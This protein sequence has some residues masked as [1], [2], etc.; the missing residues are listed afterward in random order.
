MTLSGL[1]EAQLQNWLQAVR[2]IAALDEAA[3]LREVD[4]LAF[5]LAAAVENADREIGEELGRGLEAGKERLKQDLAAARLNLQY[6]SRIGAF[7]AIHLRQS[8]YYTE[9]EAERQEA[10]TLAEQLEVAFAGAQI[11]RALIEPIA[12][13]ASLPKH[14]RAIDH[15]VAELEKRSRLTPELQQRARA[16]KER[17]ARFRAQKKLDEAEVAEAGGN[18]KKTARLRAEADVV[19]AQDWARA[20]PSDAAPA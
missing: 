3:A 16:A 18:A 15:A 1:T 2:R 9:D 17:L 10:A 8:A 5:G 7:D 20:F 19:L 4:T 12:S 11:E 6:P 13:P 14:Y